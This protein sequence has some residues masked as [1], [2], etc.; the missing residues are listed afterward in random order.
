[1]A[2]SVKCPASA[3]VMILHFHS[4]H[5]LTFLEFEPHVGLC[6]DSSEP[7]ACF[8]FCVS[9]SLWPSSAHALPLSVSKASLQPARRQLPPEFY[10]RWGCVSQ[11]LTSEN[12]AAWTWSNPLIEQR[13][14]AS[15][16]QRTFVQRFRGDG[17]HNTWQAPGFT[18]PWRLCASTS[19][20]GCSPSP[21]G[22]LP[23]GRLYGLYQM[24]SKQG[25][26]FS[27][28]PPGYL[29]TMLPTPGGLAVLPCQ[30]ITR[31]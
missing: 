5:D 28:Y 12:P 26:L 1:M 13:P 4:G 6:A 15:L 30:S 16:P 24:P 7:G 10:L 22:P 18:A 3:Q 9:L 20:G 11:S 17:N 8:G 25:N 31:G 2:Q 29:Q 27:P 19:K 23:V 14:G 21:L